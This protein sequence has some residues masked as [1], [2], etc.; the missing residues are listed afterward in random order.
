M[1][2]ACRH[3]ASAIL[4]ELDL[5]VGSG[6][7]RFPRYSLGM[8][9]AWATGSE[10]D[11]GPMEWVAAINDETGV[12]THVR[13]ALAAAVAPDA[14][15][16]QCQAGLLAVEC[17]TYLHGGDADLDPLVHAWLRDKH[18]PAE[19]ALRATALEVLAQLRAGSALATHWRAEPAEGQTAWGVALDHLRD[20]VATARRK[21]DPRT[22]PRIVAFGTGFVAAGPHLRVALVTDECTDEPSV[23]VLVAPGLSI[24]VH[25]AEV[26][27]L[28]PMAVPIEHARAWHRPAKEIAKLAA[29]RTRAVSDLRTHTIEHEGFEISL[30]FGNSSFTAGLLPYAS[31]LFEGSAPHGVLVAAPN[32][33]TVAYHRIVAAAWKAAAVELIRQVREIYESSAQ[34]VS[35]QLWWWHKGKLVE[36]PYQLVADAVLIEPVAAFVKHV[37]ELG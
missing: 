6:A 31:L 11:Q 30:A 24:V 33:G 26:D 1:P 12:A 7:P 15:V 27:G 2:S 34:Q 19:E 17:V 28:E 29:K 16:A 10:H 22:D 4:A 14:T 36:L 32:Q 8:Q 23:H 13:A 3:F 5:P 20:R 35:T 25:Y 9:R 37:K 21:P 18:P